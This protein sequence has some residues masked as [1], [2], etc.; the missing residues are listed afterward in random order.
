[1]PTYTVS[2]AANRLT[3]RQK[4]RIAQEITRIHKAVTGAQSFFAQVI[5]AEIAPGNHFVGGNPLQHDLIFVHGHIRAGR[6]PEQKQ[7]LLT[8]LVAAVALAANAPQN[9]IWA[10]VNDLPPNQM[11]EFGHILPEPGTEAD[12]LRGLPPEDRSLMERIGR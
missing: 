9:A 1:M 3:P 8:Q 6:T 12:W 11:V 2:T 7:E 4:A 5:F 10:Y